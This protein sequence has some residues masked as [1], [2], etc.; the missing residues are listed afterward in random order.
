MNNDGDNL[1]LSEKQSTF[2]IY[3]AMK[4]VKLLTARLL[5]FDRRPQ[6]YSQ[7]QYSRHQHI[8]NDNR[9]FRLKNRSRRIVRFVIDGDDFT[10]RVI[11]RRRVGKPTGDDI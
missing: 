5:R 8:V 7:T 3:R 2:C 9:Q 1:F 11:S 4:T 6:P 10:E